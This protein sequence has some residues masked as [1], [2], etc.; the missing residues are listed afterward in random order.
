MENKKN[1]DRLDLEDVDRLM[2]Q[3]VMEEGSASA[4][5]SLE[6]GITYALDQEFEDPDPEKEAAFL[7]RLKREKETNGKGMGAAGEIVL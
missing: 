3:H 1:Y 4:K 7:K 5:R 2:K 6:V